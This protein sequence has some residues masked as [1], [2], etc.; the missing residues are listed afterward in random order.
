MLTPIELG[1]AK[2][3]GNYEGVINFR[4]NG[5]SADTIT[6]TIIG[7]IIGIDMQNNRYKILIK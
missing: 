4:Y 1:Y 3:A 2:D 6:S 7:K 5:N